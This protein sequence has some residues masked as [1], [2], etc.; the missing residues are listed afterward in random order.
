MADQT[1][2]IAG[3]AGYLLM[4]MVSELV[5]DRDFQDKQSLCGRPKQSVF[6]RFRVGYT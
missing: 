3:F 2:E 1:K 4:L 6:G 5:S